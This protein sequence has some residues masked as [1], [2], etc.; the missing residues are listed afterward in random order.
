M[1]AVTG[2]MLNV[3]QMDCILCGMQEKNV[4]VPIYIRA[5]ADLKVGL[6]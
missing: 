5:G 4:K 1:C 6:S 3:L 2:S